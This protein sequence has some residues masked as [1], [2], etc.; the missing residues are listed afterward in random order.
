MSIARHDLLLQFGQPRFEGAYFI[1]HRVEMAQAGEILQPV[2]VLEERHRPGVG[3]RPSESTC[4]T[5]VPAETLTSSA[6]VRWPRIIARAAD[7]AARADRGAAGDADAAGHRGVGADADV[8]RRSG[9]G[10]RA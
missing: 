2:A 4:A 3:A 9:S 8:V 10:C 7:G 5:S 1:G 6:I